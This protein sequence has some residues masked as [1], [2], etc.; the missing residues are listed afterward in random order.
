VRVETL[1]GMAAALETIALRFSLW[2]DSTQNEVI[3]PSLCRLL[4]NVTFI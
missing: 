4:Y 1:Q 3:G 2:L